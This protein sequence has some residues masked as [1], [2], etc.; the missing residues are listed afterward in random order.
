MVNL[1][2][3]HNQ[4]FYDVL[5][6]LKRKG[7][8]F[9]PQT[10]QD[11]PYDQLI[12]AASG[13]AGVCRCPLSDVIREKQER[14]ALLLGLPKAEFEKIKLD[15]LLAG[16]LMEDRAY[17]THPAPSW[18]DLGIVAKLYFKLSCL[19]NHPHD[20][21]NRLSEVV[22]FL[23]EAEGVIPQQI[24]FSLRREFQ[25]GL[26]SKPSDDWVRDASTKA[27]NILYGYVTGPEVDII[28]KL[29]LMDY[30]CTAGCFYP[31]SE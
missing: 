14:R 16:D 25:S 23:R 17:Q 4:D 26:L 9:S 20:A 11:I 18:N 31:L 29:E 22:N 13:N 21:F 5:E 24:A 2:Y 10:L 30:V 27:S 12:L 8:K 3:G 19:E 7:E 1:I 28:D 6:E 15:D